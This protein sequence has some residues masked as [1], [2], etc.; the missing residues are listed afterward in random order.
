MEGAMSAEVTPDFLSRLIASSLPHPPASCADARNNDNDNCYPGSLTR[1][2]LE[3]LIAWLDPPIYLEAEVLASQQSRIGSTD[4][5]LNAT[6]KSS[7]F[8]EI[9]SKPC[10][11]CGTYTSS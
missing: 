7:A 9:T 5:H 4:S 10:P 6:D 2:E 11:S 8:I 1:V 3:K